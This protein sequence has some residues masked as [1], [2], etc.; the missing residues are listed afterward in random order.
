MGKK[1]KLTSSQQLQLARKLRAYEKK[2]PGALKDKKKR[3]QK[4]AIFVSEI[5]R[6]EKK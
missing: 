4:V 2:N 5:L 1:K 6:G 3:A